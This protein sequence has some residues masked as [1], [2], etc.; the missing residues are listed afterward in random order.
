MPEHFCQEH[1][2]VFF[3]K[4]AM[5]GFAHPILDAN[6]EKTGAWCNEPPEAKEGLPPPTK[7][8]VIES[9]IPKSEPKPETISG[10]T[11][12]M[13]INN[14]TQLIC[15][16]Q[17]IITFEGLAPKVMAWYKSQMLHNMGILVETPLVKAAKQLGAEEEP[18]E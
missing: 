1:Q 7:P 16:K 12:G 11:V 10:V 14:I 15:A 6:G 4:G 3:K 5:R 9:S 2:A 8:K 13:T 18:Q 17:V